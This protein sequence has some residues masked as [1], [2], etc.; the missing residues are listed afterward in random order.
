VEFSQNGYG[1]SHRFGYEGVDGEVR[2]IEASDE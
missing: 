2:I 1:V